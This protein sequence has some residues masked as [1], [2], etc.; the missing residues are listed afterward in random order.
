MAIE[1]VFGKLKADHVTSGY[2][3]TVVQT[4]VFDGGLT[5]RDYFAGLA[6]L[7]ALS[8]ARVLADNKTSARL[9][10]VMADAMLEERSK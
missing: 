6:M 2:G 5:L 7:G 3:G 1:S 8:S 4:Y 9:A 10:Y